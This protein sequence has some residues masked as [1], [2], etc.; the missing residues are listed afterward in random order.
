MDIQGKIRNVSADGQYGLLVTLEADIV[1]APSLV[2][3][4]RVHVTEDMEVRERFLRA[5]ELL[6]RQLRGEAGRYEDLIARG[7]GVEYHEKWA[8]MVQELREEADDLEGLQA[9]DPCQCKEPC[10]GPCRFEAYHSPSVCLNRDDS[11]CTYCGHDGHTTDDDCPG[12]MPEDADPI[13]ECVVGS[14]YCDGSSCET[15]RRFKTIDDMP[16]YFHRQP[17]EAP[18][19]VDS[20]LAMIQLW[21]LLDDIDTLD[22]AVKGDDVAYRR[23]AQAIQKLRWDIWNPGDSELEEP[24]AICGLCAAGEPHSESICRTRTIDAEADVVCSCTSATPEAK[25]TRN[26]TCSVHGRPRNDVPRS[27]PLDPAPRI[28]GCPCLY[29]RSL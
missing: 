19:G 26:V 7:V 3:G 12:N 4:S 23:T 28:W 8:E 16:C 29:C 11:S 20:H 22:D 18:K 15:C 17:P 14:L 6:V 13:L 25:K 9:A 2:V 21:K 1:D 24:D 5:R 27:E 10:T